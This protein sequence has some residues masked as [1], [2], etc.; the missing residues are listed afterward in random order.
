MTQ[1]SN[2]DHSSQSNETKDLLVKIFD[3]LLTMEG[4]IKEIRQEVKTAQQETEK[5][6]KEVKTAQEETNKK[7]SA[8]D[9][10]LWALSLILIGAAM[11]AFITITLSVGSLALK[12]L[13]Q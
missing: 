3:R 8:W 11:T 7:V 1:A 5:Q 6:I 4:Q 2:I 12:V 13:A 9:A 10:R